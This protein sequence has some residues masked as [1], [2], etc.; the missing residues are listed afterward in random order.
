[1]KEQEIFRITL[2]P[3]TCFDYRETR[4]SENGQQDGYQ[5]DLTKKKKRFGFPQ[6]IHSYVEFLVNLSNFQK[7][8]RDKF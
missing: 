5:K 8:F 7:T 4:P 3:K 2:K 1:M 6:P